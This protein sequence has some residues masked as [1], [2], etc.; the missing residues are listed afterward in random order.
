[1]SP[2]TRNWRDPSQYEFYTKLTPRLKAWEFLRRNEKY[3][4]DWTDAYRDVDNEH[5]V[6]ILCDPDAQRDLQ[7]DDHGIALYRTSSTKIDWGI[8]EYCNPDHDDPPN[9]SFSRLGDHRHT[10]NFSKVTHKDRSLLTFKVPWETFSKK[11]VEFLLMAVYNA[12]IHGPQTSLRL[13]FPIDLCLPISPQLEIIKQKLMPLQKHLK[14]QRA[15][16]VT[17]PVSKPDLH[18]QYLRILDGL[19]DGVKKMEVIRTI[20]P[21]ETADL[22]PSEL[23]SVIRDKVKAAIEMSEGGYKAIMLSS[24]KK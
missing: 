23:Q 21:D 2:L 24:P 11:N 13:D 17:K 4:N 10:E 20:F 7:D 9:L 6:T 14:N 3:I 22:D 1:M 12:N 18:P 15:I 16:S 8:Y 5:Q 19:A